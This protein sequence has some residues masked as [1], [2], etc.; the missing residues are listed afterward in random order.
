MTAM[1]PSFTRREFLEKTAIAGAAVTL[2]QF[3]TMFGQAAGTSGVIAPSPSWI[4]TPMR[5]AQLTLVEDD[6]GKFDLA[7]WLNYFKSTHSDAACLSAGGSVA[8]YPTK[9]PLHYR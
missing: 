5:W 1:T 3:A 4:D 6:P 8:F 2:G 7:F 9:I